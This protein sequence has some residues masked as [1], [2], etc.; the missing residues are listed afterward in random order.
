MEIVMLNV[1]KINVVKIKLGAL[2]MHSGE[3]KREPKENNKCE[4]KRKKG[5]EQR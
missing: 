3:L 4:R 2:S 1:L 5:R